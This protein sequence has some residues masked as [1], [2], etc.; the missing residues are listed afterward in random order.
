MECSGAS[1]N[2][3]L[4]CDGRSQSYKTEALD[5]HGSIFTA[6]NH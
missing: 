4:S 1:I 6:R 5:E 3:V 2:P